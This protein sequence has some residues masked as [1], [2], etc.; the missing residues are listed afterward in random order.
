M[1]PCSHPDNPHTSTLLLKKFHDAAQTRLRAF[2]NRNTFL[3][4]PSP[5][6]S[7]RCYS[8]S[9]VTQTTTPPR[10]NSIATLAANGIRPNPSFTEL[11]EDPTREAAATQPRHPSPCRASHATTPSATDKLIAIAKRCARHIGLPTASIAACRFRSCA[12][13]QINPAG[14]SLTR[15]ADTS[16]ALRIAAVTST[17]S[18]H[19]RHAAT[20]TRRSAAHASGQCPCINSSRTSSWCEHFRTLTPHL[21]PATGPQSSAEPGTAAA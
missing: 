18:P 20:C 9:T 21:R 8:R 4:E 16:R 12:R 1:Q 2:L 14:S 17:I 7:G 10:N 11:S 5:G 13:H 15:C 19:S 6:L 3:I